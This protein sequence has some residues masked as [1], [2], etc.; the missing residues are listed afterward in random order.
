MYCNMCRLEILNNTRQEADKQI[1]RNMEEKNGIDFCIE[2]ELHIG[3]TY[4]KQEIYYT[5]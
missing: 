1:W 5:Y 4:Y 2:N 3:N